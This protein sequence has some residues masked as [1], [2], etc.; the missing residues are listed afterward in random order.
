MEDEMWMGK[1]ILVPIDFSD[2][3]RVAIRAGVELAQRLQV[4]LVLLHVHGSPSPL[5][6]EMDLVLAEQ[7]A[8]AVESTARLALNRERAMLQDEGIPISTVLERGV[9]WE[10]ILEAAK[11]LD[12]GMI[13]L[14]THGRRGLPRALLG[15]VAEKVVR[16]SPIP[17]LTVHEAPASPSASV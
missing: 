17:V 10:R 5:Y 15:S 4:P 14:G 7:F 11:S 3:S 13:I 6:E 12:A 2:C 8:R 1:R 16:L 9:A